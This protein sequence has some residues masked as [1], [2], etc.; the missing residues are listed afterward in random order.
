MAAAGELPVSFP[1]TAPTELPVGWFCAVVVVEEPGSCAVLKG[2]FPACVRCAAGD[3]TL[4]GAGEEK[5]VRCE[6]EFG[7]AALGAGR[8]GCFCAGFVVEGVGVDI[9]RTVE[10]ARG[11][12]SVAL[13]EAGLFEKH[14]I[15]VDYGVFM[16]QMALRCG[17]VVACSYAV[18]RVQ[19]SF[20][21][22]LRC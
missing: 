3:C 21:C 17:R 15:G 10:D 19:C 7:V 22:A 13:G 2:D 8:G 5:A 11:Y 4:R 14:W 18:G 20:G 6:K 12:G 16:V 9:F 1:A